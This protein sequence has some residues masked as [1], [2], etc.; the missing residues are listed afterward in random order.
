MGWGSIAKI[1]SSVNPVVAFS[2]AAQVAGDIYSAQQQ[3]KGQQEAN[4]ATI[5]SS[6][7]Q[8]AFQERM[9]NTAHQRE[10]AD[11]K[12]AGLNPALSANSGASTPV[13]SSATSLNAAPDYRGIMQNAIGTAMKSMQMKKDFEEADSRIDA[14][15]ASAELARTNADIGKTGI[16][17]KW[18]GS[19]FAT[20][21]KTVINDI[22]ERIF[23]RSKER[24]RSRDIRWSIKDNKDGKKGKILQDDSDWKSLR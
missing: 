18:F 24:E 5:N 19:K 2:T 10:V 4:E 14:N 22:A 23:L 17:V 16:A 21:A 11:L 9:S 15:R 13:G 7:E 20:N 8:M 1:A 6:R 12:L 3:R